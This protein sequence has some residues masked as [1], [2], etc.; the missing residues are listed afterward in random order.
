MFFLMQKKERVVFVK[1]D[2]SQEIS[3]K[4]LLLHDWMLSF[5]NI[6][7]AYLQFGVNVRS[8]Q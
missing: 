3:F 2:F 4:S 6:P 8:C 7:T 1:F 5:S